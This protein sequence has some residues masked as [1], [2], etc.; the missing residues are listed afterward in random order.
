MEYYVKFV[1][2]SAYVVTTTEAWHALIDFVTEDTTLFVRGG[3]ITGRD[4]SPFIAQLPG[5]LDELNNMVRQNVAHRDITWTS[6]EDEICLDSDVDPAKVIRR[7]AVRFR[8]LE[9]ILEQAKQIGLQI[10]RRPYADCI[11][12]CGE[13]GIARVEGHGFGVLSNGKLIFEPMK[14]TTLVKGT[15]HKREFVLSTVPSSG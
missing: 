5:H 12:E 15:K 10:E 2:Y 14:C 1:G 3:S 8:K 4:L 6:G 7:L 13:T 9:S 11:D